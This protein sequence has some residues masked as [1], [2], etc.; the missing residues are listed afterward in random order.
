MHRLLPALFALSFLATLP[1]CVSDSNSR[2]Q[3]FNLQTTR[4]T[5]GLITT[6][7]EV[8]AGEW[9]IADE[10]VVANPADSRIIAKSMDGQVDTFTVEEAK[11]MANNPQQ[12]P[13]HGSMTSTL[14]MGLMAYYLF[15]RPMGSF[16]PQRGAYMD[17]RTYDRTT[18]NA[19]QRLQR[20]AAR[21]PVR[22]NAPRS[23]NKGYGGSRSTRSV[24]G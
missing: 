19:G 13:R 15:A 4:P 23:G 22:N 10:T 2:E 14:G 5:E 8:S 6:V 9:K 1:G 24:G 18:Q 3:T 17:Q 21:A 16:R 20:S 11:L 7:Q 12:Y